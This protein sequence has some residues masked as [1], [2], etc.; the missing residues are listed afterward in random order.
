MK[1][2]FSNI[3]MDK[4]VEY[5]RKNNKSPANSVVEA[6]EFLINEPLEG[7]QRSESKEAT[8]TNRS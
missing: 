2:T 7:S 1:V 8:H 3:L 5:S 6:V 4:L